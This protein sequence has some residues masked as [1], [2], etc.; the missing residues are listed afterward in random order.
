MS[1]EKTSVLTAIIHITETGEIQANWR[2]TIT[3]DSEVISIKTH[4]EVYNILQRDRMLL[5]VEGVEP[6]MLLA[7]WT[8][9]AHQEALN[10]QTVVDNVPAE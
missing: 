6:Y 8:D 5:E 4:S 3:D 2:N 10:A 9:E 1:L 7:G